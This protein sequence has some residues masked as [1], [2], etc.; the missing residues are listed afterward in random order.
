L[1][2]GLYGLY[3][4]LTDGIEKA[5]IVDM[6]A[7]E[8]KASALGLHATLTGIALLPASLIAGYLFQFVG[9]SAP[10]FFSS[11]VAFVVTMLL[12]RL[13]PPTSKPISNDTIPL[14]S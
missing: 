4:A 10:F 12:L 11:I 14:S 13:L 2:F 5:L 8:Q 7:P 9:T 6:I 3:V 1:L